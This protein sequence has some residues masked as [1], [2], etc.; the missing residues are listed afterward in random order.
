MHKPLEDQNQ[1]FPPIMHRQNQDGD[2][3][4]D[5]ANINQDALIERRHIFDVADILNGGD[6]DAAGN[7]FH[8]RHEAEDESGG[9]GRRRRATLQ[10]RWK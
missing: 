9:G 4:C 7:F 8:R 5:A 6:D 1:L 3:T 10:F 2:A